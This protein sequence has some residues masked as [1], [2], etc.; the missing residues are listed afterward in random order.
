MTKENFVAMSKEL[1]VGYPFVAALAHALSKKMPV[2]IQSA[3]ATMAPNLSI[4]AKTLTQ[5]LE[6]FVLSTTK[7]TAARIVV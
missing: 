2:A 3:L 4:N 7:K 1:G 6:R 5:R